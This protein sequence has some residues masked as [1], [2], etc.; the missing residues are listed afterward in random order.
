MKKYTLLY[1][2]VVALALVSCDYNEDNFDGFEDFGKPTDIKKGNITFT[3]WASLKGNPKTNQYFSAADEAQDYLPNWLAGQYPSA[4]EGSSFKITFDYKE[5]KSEKHDK[6]Y[7]ID[8]YKLKDDDYKIIHGKGYYGAYLNKSTTSKLYKVLNEVFPDAKEGSHVFAEYNYNADAIPQKMDDPVF[9]YDFESLET[10]DVTSIK[11]WYI[12]ATGGAKWSLKSYN[13]NQYISYSANGKGACEAW[14]V[15][16]SVEI[17]DEN[18]KFAFEVCVGYWNADCLSVLIST[19]FDGKDVS[20][21]KWTDITSSFD[22][23]QEPSKG[24]GTLA[25]AGTF[26][27]TD[28][29]G[30][31]VN[32]AFKY[33][34]NGDD[35]KSTTYQLDNITIGNDIPVLVKSEPQYAFYEK[36]AKGW[37]VVN[38]EDVF[39]LTP[40]DYTAM[41]EP[42]KNF[43][44]SSSVLA[45]DYLPAYLAKKVAYPLNDAEKIIVYKYYSGS[46]KAYSD[47]YIY[48]TANARWGKNTYMTTKTEQYVKTSGKWNYDPSVV[49]NLPNGK[50]QADISVYYQAI[51]D[52]VW[53]NID[54]KELGISKKG[55]GYTTT[56]ASPT[57]SEYYFGATAYQNN[58]DLRPAKF[59]EQY[60]KGYEGMDDAKITETVMARLPK[61]FIP[62]LEKNHADAVPV[63]GI[64]VTYTVNF[65]IY[66]GS[67][68]VNWTAVYKVVGNGKFE[69]VEDSMKKVE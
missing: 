40:D 17:E 63:E 39:V 48:S 30:K 46:V 66:D 13:D 11:N 29:V 10:G 15:T 8:Y 69:Y 20:K 54:Q 68:N 38:D 50:D 52:W 21:A 49:V 2:A 42:G 37:N 9:S 41:G 59:R 12:S 4:D 16:P 67:S 33:V 34:G 60:A 27:L 3:D 18:N 53:E 1:S 47:S 58:I 5:E 14:L 25:L 24:Y 61:A 23:P 56:Y 51:V 36:S 28:Y 6:Y 31:N 19:D 57:G 44:F 22:I 45:E 35:E 32:I 7:N 26:N 65:V 62:A 64:D 55:D 43:N